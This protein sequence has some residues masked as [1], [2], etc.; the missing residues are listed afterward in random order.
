LISESELQKLAAFVSEGAPAVSLYLDTDLTQKP[1][2]RCKLILR[3]HLDSLGDSL[4]EENRHAI[5]RFFDLEYDWQSR[6]VALFSALDQGTW[7]FYPLDVPPLSQAHAGK[8][9]YILP[10]AEHAAQRDR[11]GVVIVD[12]EGA[13]F[14]LVGPGRVEETG[15]WVGQD[16]KRHKQGGFA[17]ARFQRHVDKQAEQNL[18]LAAEA[19]ARF[20][21]ESQ[22]GQ[23]VLGGSEETIPQFEAMLPKALQKEVVGTLSLDRSTPA[24]EVMERSLELLRERERERQSR[25]V[26][27]LLTTAAKGGDAVSGQTDTFYVA[28]DGRAR[29]LVLEKGF[30]REGYSCTRCGYV[31]PEHVEPCPFCGGALEKVP[32]AVNL[33][34]LKVIAAGGRIELVGGSAPLADAGHIGAVVRY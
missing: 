11:C 12:R 34:A 18:K 5:E 27:S 13:R 15:E 32:D 17:A 25:L 10:L 21:H 14:L 9:L 23:I 33:V 3:E 22:C 24:T 2:E 29:T 1:K 4:S 6:G 31:S 19:T 7:H 28:H 30:E 16:L 8:R 20:C 26:E